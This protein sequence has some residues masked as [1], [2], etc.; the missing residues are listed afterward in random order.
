M[1]LKRQITPYKLLN[2]VLNFA[3]AVRRRPA[4]TALP[5]MIEIDINNICNLKCP[6][7]PTGIGEHHKVNGEMSYESFCQIVDEVKDYVFV[8]VLFN[9]GEPFMHKDVCKMIE[10]A[11]AGGISVIT[12]TNGNFFHVG[13][14]AERLVRSGLD[15][16]IV[17]ISGVSQDVYGRYHQNGKVDRVI[18]GLRK[19]AQ[20]KRDSNVATPVLMLRYLLFD[21]NH[22]ELDQAR[23]LAREV[24]AQLNI[25]RAGTRE[26]YHRLKAAMLSERSADA[27]PV[28]N[29]CY[30]LWSLPLIQYDG[31]VRPCC[32][33][34]LDPPDQGNVCRDGGVAQVWGGE[35]FREFRTQML[36]DKSKIPSC[37]NCTSFPGLQDANIRKLLRWRSR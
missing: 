11:H 21:Y 2:C 17:S 5:S 32:I 4:V 26:D 13:D 33:L 3:Y 20:A 1:V 30:W 25:R 6:A 27:P 15:V 12:S 18:A 24:G 14:H 16:L 29:H 19:I 36:T 22:S 37:R 7:C 31:D 34:N 23:Q 10:Y 28:T 9:S 8:I 35:T